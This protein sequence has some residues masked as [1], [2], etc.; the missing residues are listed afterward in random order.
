MVLGLTIHC[1][2]VSRTLSTDP[3]RNPR[4]RRRN[5]DC[6]TRPRITVDGSDWKILSK[7]RI[8]VVFEGKETAVCEAMT[9]SEKSCSFG[10]DR[11]AAIACVNSRS[12]TLSGYRV[13]VPAPRSRFKVQTRFNFEIG[14]ARAD[15]SMAKCRRRSSSASVPRIQAL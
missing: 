8:V 14:S 2:T 1:N 3:E 5:A 4:A 6:F 10:F 7:R 9:I 12:H 15:R 13:L 11:R